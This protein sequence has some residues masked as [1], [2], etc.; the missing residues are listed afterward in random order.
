MFGKKKK[1]HEITQE[2]RSPNKIY[3]YEP[4]ILLEKIKILSDEGDFDTIKKNYK[5]FN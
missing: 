5:N 4:Y 3:G 2:T 1:S